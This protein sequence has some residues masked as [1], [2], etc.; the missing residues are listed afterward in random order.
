VLDTRH[1]NEAGVDA[2]ER[3]RQAELLLNV[4]KTLAAFETLDEVLATLVQFMSSELGAE[5]ATLFLNDPETGELY[6]RVAQG[7]L[8]REIR[9]PNSVG[10]AGHVFSTGTGIIVHDAYSNEHF[11]PAIDE[12][13]GFTTRSLVCAPVRTVRGQVIGVAQV[14]NKRDGEFDARDMSTLEAISTQAAIALQTTALVERMQ[15]TRKQEM[16]FLDVV[17]DVTSE[18]DLPALL[19][20]VMSEATKMLNAERSTLFLNDDRTGELYTVIGEGLGASQL[21]LPN[22]VGIAGAVF[23]TGETINIPHAYA[24]LRFSPAFDKQTGFFT[25]SILC[26]PVVNKAGKTIGV[27]QVLNKHGGPFTREDE[28]RLR[29]FTAQVSMALEHAK[30]FDDVQNMKNYNESILESMSSG[31][32]TLDEDER[33]VTCNASGLK[34]LQV[35]AEDIVGKPATE[36][37][38]GD[39]DWLLDRLSRVKDSREA[40]ILMDVEMCAGSNRLY[41][42]VTILPLF[43]SEGR[44]LGS[45]IMIEDVSSEKRL[46]STM[47]RYMDPAIADQLLH[48]GGEVLAGTNT[49]ATVLFSDIRGFTPLTEELGATATVGLLNEYFTIVVDCVQRQGGMLD[50]FVGDA[51]MAIFGLPVAHEDDE[52]RAVRAAVAMMTELATWNRQRVEDGKKP[53]DIGIG[54][55][56]DS[57]VSGSIGSPK[58]MDYTVIGDGVNLASRLESACKQYKSHILM[59]EF[60]YRKL[61]GTYRIREVDRVIV[62]GRSTPVG[63][64]EVLDY[65]TEETFPSMR[66]VLGHFR[67]GVTRYRTRNWD[68][69]IKAFEEALRLNPNDRPCQL[70]I[71]RCRYLKEN[72]PADDWDGVWVLE[73]K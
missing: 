22:H 37:F 19:R 5:R 6:S 1:S 28:S 7:N 67:D 47:S 31:V 14:L 11:N 41:V 54:L 53:V 66:E 72:A 29:A 69:A 57:I 8:Q 56:T 33:I 9:M 45:M 30:L 71:E 10:V 2:F 63:V 23:T 26:V 60:T 55:N 50:K 44:R 4:S 12:L 20:K 15:K 42:N 52:D 27:T 49:V 16:E 61:R 39:N 59:S 73:S 25:R 46:K 65:H 24:D 70:Y 3:L 51:M 62:I 40:D 13:T 32:I 21:R 36:F 34:I 48:S 17:S 58:R 64:Y 38:A 18:I 68:A 43:S 35:R